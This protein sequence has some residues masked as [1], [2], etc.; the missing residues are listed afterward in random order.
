M[1]KLS[2]QRI[3]IN[4]RQMYGVP[5]YT[6]SDWECKSY[7]NFSSFFMFVLK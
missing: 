6:K 5:V 2:K 4:I 3:I 1:Q 7:K